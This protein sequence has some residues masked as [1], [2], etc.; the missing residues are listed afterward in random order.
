[1]RFTLALFAVAAYAAVTPIV[2]E[3]NNDNGAVETNNDDAALGFGVEELTEAAPSDLETRDGSKH[4]L[5]VT[6]WK[7]S[8]CMS[9]LKSTS[10]L[11]K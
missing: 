2:V 3:T 1:M 5:E 9:F 8:N 6:T 10:L 11:S 4:F 7:T